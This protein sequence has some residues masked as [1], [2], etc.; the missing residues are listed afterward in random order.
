ML[1]IADGV[2]QI[3]LLPRSAVNAYLVGDVLVDAGYSSHGK[4]VVA[5]VAGREVRVHALTHVHSDHAGGSR[6]VHEA[7][8]V[9][10]WI[11]AA[12]APYLRDGRAAVPPGSRAGKLLGRVAKAPAVPVD[13]ELREGDELGH[14]FVVL[15][16][17]GH[18]PGHV[19]FWR[20]RDRTL[21]AGD[22]FFNMSLLTTAPGLREPPDLFTYDI[23]Q[24][25]ASERR[26]ADLDPSVVAFGHGPVLREPGALRA[27][28]AGR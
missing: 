9:P 2:W 22:V 17:P 8:G 28:L 5:A 23:P 10:V 1:E 25:R 3:P 13:R 20:E 12:D 16:V 26:L 27:F 7:L 21:I 24:N 6:R 4:K 14:G 19:A 15:D 18:S 11:G